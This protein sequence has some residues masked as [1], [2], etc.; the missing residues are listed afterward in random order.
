[1]QLKIIWLFKRVYWLFIGS[2]RNSSFCLS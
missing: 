1:M 2:L